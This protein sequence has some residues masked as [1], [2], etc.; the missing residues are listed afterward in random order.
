LQQPRR[1]SLVLATL[2][3]AALPG[4]AAV[5]GD[6]P[7]AP[8]REKASLP[9][10][11]VARVRGQDVTLADFRRRLV[12]MVRPELDDPR[13]GPATVFN[14]VI[15]QMVVV[16]EAKRLGIVVTNEDYA[17]EYDRIDRQVR[18]KSGG[19]QT[20]ADVIREADSTPE[21]TRA[22][23]E[24]HLRKERI[25]SHPSYLGATLPRDEG[26]R[27]AQIEV[28]MGDLMRKA[29]VVK[30][31]LPPGVMATVDGAPMTV[32]MLGEQLDLRLGEREV[33]RLLQEHCL[34]VLLDQEG[35]RF[36]EA[37]VDEAL[38]FEKP[39]YE[40]MLE[41]AIDPQKRSLSFDDFLLL[42]YGAPVAELRSSPYRRGLFALRMR[43]WREVSEED[44]VREFGRESQK[45]YGAS[46]VVTDFQ[47]SYE[48]PS[49]LVQT[50][51]RRS[52]EEALR[53]ARDISRRGHAGE[54]AESLRKEIAAAKDR[55]ITAERRAIFDG[56][57]DIKLFAAASKLS[58]RSWSE[59]IERYNSEYH[60]LFREAARPAPEFK[61]VRDVV[62]NDLVDVRAKAWLEKALRE[63]VQMA[64]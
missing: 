44:V 15:E 2:L 26:A 21:V 32:E 17:R 42:R 20:F 14:I 33:R 36:S 27:I 49:A 60:V 57:G 35:L 12:E 50:A 39:L 7:A 30:T 40:R 31:G 29:K 22:R 9:P 18:A 13:S 54:S 3:C 48:L 58:D 4:S 37:Q 61:K 62:H 55:S 43:F 41:T 10:G 53:I 1:R 47:V 24:E 25:A 34:T 8:R 64:R 63:E 16:Q 51:P 52:H 23:L 6:A 5:A 59:P 56:S 11:I 19:K 46:I 45:K 28:V 38:I